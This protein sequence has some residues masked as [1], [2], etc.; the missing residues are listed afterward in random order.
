[1]N[2][3]DWVG[4]GVAPKLFRDIRNQRE[5]VAD[6]KARLCLQ[7]GA[8]CAQIPEE[9]KRG[10]TVQRVREWKAVRDACMKVAGSHRSSVPILEHALRWITNWN[11]PMP[12]VP[13]A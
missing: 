13:N 2:Q 10:G 1:M 12:K 5:S 6:Q 11:K 9:I 3:I 4:G 8:L 7:I